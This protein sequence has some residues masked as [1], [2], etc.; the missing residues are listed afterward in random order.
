MRRI[1]TINIEK[2]I[3]KDQIT[4]IYSEEEKIRQWILREL[5]EVYKYPLDLIKLE[6]KINMG[7]RIGLADIAVN[8]YRKKVKAPY[9]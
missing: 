7:S 5:K 6:E 2:Y 8:I 4:D 3:L 9:I 1:S